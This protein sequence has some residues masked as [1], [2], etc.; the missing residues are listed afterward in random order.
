M[1]TSGVHTGR[2][3]LENSQGLRWYPPLEP[4]SLP[5]VRIESDFDAP[6]KHGD[7]VTVELQTEKVG[8][9]AVTLRYRVF[10]D[11]WAIRSDL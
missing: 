11:L 5:V 8:V 6:L 3:N 9:H 4:G 2:V 10:P 7:L 1:I